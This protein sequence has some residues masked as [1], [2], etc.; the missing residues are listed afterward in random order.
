MSKQNRDRFKT[1]LHS[2][3]GAVLGAILGLSTSVGWADN[4]QSLSTT[5]LY[6]SGIAVV[7]AVSAGLFL[8]RFWEWLKNNSKWF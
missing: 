5:I 7:F 6:I 8:D 3:C 1:I 2:T 4:D